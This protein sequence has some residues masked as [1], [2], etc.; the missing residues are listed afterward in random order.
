MEEWVGLIQTLW[1]GCEHGMADAAETLEVVSVP[2]ERNKEQWPW[3][4]LSVSKPLLNQPTRAQTKRTRHL[5]NC[6]DKQSLRMFATMTGPGTT[7]KYGIKDENVSEDVVF[8]ACLLVYLQY[9]VVLKAAMKA[10]KKLNVQSPQ[11]LG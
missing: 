5:A 2:S 4:V 7:V 9:Q 3:I 1:H 11:P 10:N 8:A 6:L